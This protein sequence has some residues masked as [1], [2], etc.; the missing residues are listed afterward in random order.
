[1]RGWIMN[2]GDLLFTEESENRARRERSFH[3][4]AYTDARREKV[5]HF[6]RITSGSRARFHKMCLEYATGASDVLEYGCGQGNFAA[7][8]ARGNAHVTGIDVSPVAIAQAAQLAAAKGVSSRVA[9]EVMNAE[10]LTFEDNSFDLVCGSAIL[11]HLDLEASY[12]EIARVLRPGG[13]A[14]FLEPLGHNLAINWYRNRTPDLRTPDEAPLRVEHLTRAEREFGLV[15]VH[16]FELLPLFIIPFWRL[17]GF[18]AG[19][20]LLG[21]LDQLLFTLIPRLRKQ[22]WFAILEMRDPKKT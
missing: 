20:R 13:R 11:H 15:K 12:R 18:H 3:D 17:P 5:S 1:M 6:Y 21:R 8:L 19:V 2:E 9:F 22:G 7:E 14:I 4:A 10:R 16:F